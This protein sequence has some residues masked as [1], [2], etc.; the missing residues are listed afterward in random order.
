MS[1]WLFNVYMDGV[2]RKVNA[3][4]L[5][6]GLSLVNNDREGKIN[7]LL[8]TDDITLVVDSKQKLVE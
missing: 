2:V 4:M 7:Q 6:R 8:F 1:S 3:K 5:S